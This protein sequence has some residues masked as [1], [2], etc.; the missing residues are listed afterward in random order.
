MLS[1]NIIVYRA[2]IKNSYP[3]LLSDHPLIFG[4]I[5]QCLMRKKDGSIIREE[6]LKEQ[7]YDFGPFTTQLKENW[8]MVRLYFFYTLIILI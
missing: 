8:R 3:A 6:D 4:S 1:S 7:N 5:Q 2:I